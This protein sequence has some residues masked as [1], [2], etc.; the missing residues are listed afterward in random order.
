M[1][2]NSD[3]GG[4]A[5]PATGGSPNNNNSQGGGSQRHRNQKQQQRINQSARFT[6]SDPQMQGHIYDIVPTTG[7]NRFVETTKE[8][9]IY[10][11]RKYTEYTADLVQSVKDLELNDPSPPAEPT[12]EISAIQ[13]KRWE[14]AEKDYRNKLK[15]YSDFRAGLYSTVLGQCTDGLKTKLESRGEFAAANQDGI[16]LLR[17]IRTVAHTFEHRSNLANEINKMKSKFY[18]IRQGKHESLV[19]YHQRFESLVDAMETVKLYN[20]DPLM[21]QQVAE[22][23]GR[24]LITATTEDVME[25][26]QKILANQFIRGAN[27]KFDSFRR[28]LENSTLNGRDEYPGTVAIALEIMERR[29]DNTAVHTPDGSGVAFATVSSSEGQHS[30]NSNGGTGAIGRFAH[31]R[32]FTCGQLGHFANRCPGQTSHHGTA[33]AQAATTIPKTWVLLDN[34]STLHLFCNQELLKD[35]CE[36]DGSMTVTSNGGTRTTKMKGTLPG[37]GDVWYDP[38]A[39]TNILSLSSVQERYRVSY[40]SHQGNTFN[41]HLD[42]G[43][44]MRFKQAMSGLHYLDTAEQEVGW[45]FV[46]TVADK[47]ARYSHGD[48]LRAVSARKLQVMIGRPSTR[49]F[50]RIVENGHLPNC[51]INRED[52]IA[53]EDIFGPDVGSL[54]GKTVRTKAPRVEEKREGLPASILSRYRE[55]TICV[56]IM[57]VNGIPFL[58]TISKHIHFGTVEALPNRKLPAI[59]KA[60]KGVVRLYQQRGFKVKWALMD[61]EFEPLRMDLAELGVGLNETGRD[62]HVPQVE[63]YI[64]TIKERARAT[65]NMLPYQQLPST[66][67]IETIKTAVFWLNAFPYEKGVSDRMSPRTIVT[68]QVVDYSKHCK[69]EFGEYVQV[70]EEHDN[71]MAPRTVGALALRPTGNAQGNW[72][73]LSLSTGRILNRTNGTKL[74][75]PGEVIERVHAMARRQKANPGLVF[76]DRIGEAG[77]T[78]DDDEDDLDDETYNPSDSDND[79]HDN[80]DNESHD[81]DSDDETHGPSDNDN[82]SHSDNE[83]HNVDD[84]DGSDNHEDNSDDDGSHNDDNNHDEGNTEP[85]SVVPHVKVETEVI[86]VGIAEDG[87]INPTADELDGEIPGVDA[88][89]GSE[90]EPLNPTN[91]EIFDPEA[92]QLEMEKQM[93]EKYGVR[94]GAYNLRR[95][96]KRQYNF[97][98]TGVVENNLATP[99]MSM[100]Q[101]IKTF[102][103]AGV[104]AVKKELQQLHYR[105]DSGAKEGSFSVPDV[106]EA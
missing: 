57:H 5:P 92:A 70:H 106:S 13:L 47:K 38:G 73:F 15:A 58:L 55:V 71:S 62:E 33:M 87:E 61:N 69:Y 49:E 8:L 12:G 88:A 79:N 83:S 41:V 10:V 1:P 86:G 2:S 7:S 18:G 36:A 27:F 48:Y 29:G 97:A 98:N 42:D 45:T 31:I 9:A 59:W 24:D 11:G 100:K 81:D 68:G 94:S 78:M 64:R 34:Q 82:D 85:V 19:H 28:E 21:V 26:R 89:D 76:M 105:P 52:I 6:G 103:E 56:D 22:S 90:T 104:L 96:K 23:N 32:C 40:D 46:T 75:M 95:R 72:Y 25:A 16:A 60:V 50:I 4:E 77:P 43:R 53:A 101:G 35:I 54:K 37:F 66:L 65:Y 80:S 44:I 20:S 84:I 14:F 3:G 63:R 51:P 99:Q 17:L 102:G 91:E 30:S 93:N 39:I 74:P 67:V